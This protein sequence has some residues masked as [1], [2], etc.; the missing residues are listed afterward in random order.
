MDSDKI[1]N[2]FKTEDFLLSDLLGRCPDNK[3]ITDNLAMAY[4]II[5]DDRY[6]S[7]ICTVSGGADSDVMMDIIYRV[8]K[9]GR[10]KYVFFDTGLEYQATKEHLDFLEQKYGVAIERR[11]AM[12]PIPTCCKEY[13]QP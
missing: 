4:A 8:D 10:V 11:K 7:I 6:E 12:K 1:S 2:S 5:N 13:G 9:G 3:I